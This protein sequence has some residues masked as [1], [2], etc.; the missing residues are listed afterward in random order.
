MLFS[1]PLI[2][3]ESPPIYLEVEV[4]LD[5]HL[6]V[7][8]LEEAHL[9]MDHFHPRVGLNTMVIRQDELEKLNSTGLTY[10]ISVHDLASAI[11]AR[12]ISDLGKYDPFEPGQEKTT[13][14]FEL[15]S[16]GGFYTF[17]EIVAQLDEMVSLYPNIITPK[18]SIGTTFEGRTIWAVKISDNP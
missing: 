17:A 12:N 11:E 8:V 15:G 3:Q 16:M 9:D 14:G 1:L 4:E 6:D 5:D 10:T 2:G 13:M 18:F 7:E